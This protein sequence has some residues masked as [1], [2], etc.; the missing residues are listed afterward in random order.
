M[1][2]FVHETKLIDVFLKEDWGGDNWGD[3]TWPNIAGSTLGINHLPGNVEGFFCKLG[4][5]A[6][7]GWGDPRS[8]YGNVENSSNKYDGSWANMLPRAFYKRDGGP[9]DLRPGKTS[10]VGFK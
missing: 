5:K 2:E 1:K 4:E 6:G 8:E 3:F 10:K 7:Y 9:F